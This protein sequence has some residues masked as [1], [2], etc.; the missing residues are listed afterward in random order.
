MKPLL[1]ILHIEDSEEDAT[2]IGLHLSAM[3]FEIESTR[4]ETAEAMQAALA[5]Q[6]WDIILCDYALPRFGALQALELVRSLGLDI[7]FIIIS[8]AIGEESAVEAMRAGASDYLMKGNLARLGPTIERELTEAF[9]RR[10]LVQAEVDLRKSE[11][12]YR[13]LLDTTYEGVWI[14]D[15][16]L[17]TTY[18]NQ[19]FAD[20]IGYESKEMIGRSALD[21]V[22][23]TARPDVEERWE[24]RAQGIKEQYD[25]C[26]RRKDGTDLWVIVCATP[27]MGDTGDFTGALSML[28]DITARK[29]VEQDLATSEERYRDLVENARDVIYTHDLSGNYTSVNRAGEQVTGYTREESLRMNLADSV[30]PEDL[31]KARQMLAR[32]LAGE[33]ITAYD[34]DIIAKDG[35]R[36]TVE[37]NTRIIRENGVALGVQ[38]IARD[39]TERKLAEES[40]RQADERYRLLFEDNPLPMWVYDLE[41]LAFLAVNEAAII[42]YGYSLEEFLT[43]TIKDIRPPEDLPALMEDLKR[44][45]TGAHE[46]RRWRHQKKDGSIIDVEITSHE[47]NFAG[48]RAQLVL[49]NDVTERRRWEGIQSVRTAQLALRADINAALA[50]KG[51]TSQRTLERCTEALVQHLGV[52]LA[53]IWTLDQEQDTLELRASSGIYTQI[54]SDAAHLTAGAAQIGLIAKT[55]E[56]FTVQDLARDDQADAWVNETG[57]I[58]FA[59][60]PLRVEER[61]VGVVAVFS[62]RPIADDLVHALAPAADT[63]SQDVERRRVEEA[64]QS[65]E[66]QLRQAQKMEAI[67]QLAGGISHDFNNILTVIAGYCEL[68]LRKLPNPDPLRN[69]LEEIRKAGDRASGLTRQLLAFSRKQ[70]LQPEVLALNQVVTNVEKMLRRLIGEN[71]DLRT[72]LDPGLGTVKADPGQIEQVIMN[73]AINARDAMPQGGRLTIETGNV[74]LDDAYADQHVTV[75]SG[76]YVMLAVTDTGTGMDA[77]TQARVFE[78]FFTTKELGKGTGL[79]LSTVYGIVKQS[80]GSIWI[81]SEIGHGTSFKIYL[82]RVDE[83]AQ[84]YQRIPETAEILQGTETVLVLEDD[85]TLRRLSRS[86]LEM[87]GYRVLEAANGADALSLCETYEG[88]IELLATD[89]VMPGMGGGEAAK[90]LV[91]LRPE[92]KV[93]F[94]S[95]YTEDTIFHQGVLDQEANFIQKPFSPDDLARKVR[96]VLD[97]EARTQ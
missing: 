50:E 36:L 83:A 71:V 56:P 11:I 24:K 17:C 84:V 94:M 57:L 37:V 14:S 40:R 39:V 1:K 42:H 73:L 23:D 48:R 97:A 22:A 21:F 10:A 75:T 33:D 12:R 29:R 67:G 25:L 90:R 45:Q 92:M 26:L 31:P 32:K 81:Y 3:R 35:H 27:I 2:L 34:L 51:T 91:E 47:L 9:N 77:Q 16:T 53:R 28:T 88:P 69:N 15:S 18:V 74:E 82:P 72:A 70:I 58:A 96:E 78:P 61:L 41:T 95:G 64:L 89:V 20:M 65:T 30:V 52:D 5:A 54:E 66:D 59:G 6:A 87:F 43:K 8:G 44:P 68:A 55:H 63:I 19:R 86:V 93:L 46:P 38:G 49:A 85:E 7:P 13:Q 80:G 4:V 62:R 76:S 60:Y 79:G